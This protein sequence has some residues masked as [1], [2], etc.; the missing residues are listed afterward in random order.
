[1]EKKPKSEKPVDSREKKDELDNQNQP[2]LSGS[3]EWDRCLA[4]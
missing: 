3:G 2:G 1:M 4:F